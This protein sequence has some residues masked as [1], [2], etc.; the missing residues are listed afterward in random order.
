M[1]VGCLEA[2]SLEASGTGESRASAR[3]RQYSK[4]TRSLPVHCQPAKFKI[5]LEAGNC[6]FDKATGL[7]R[8]KSL[9]AIVGRRVHSTEETEAFRTSPIANPE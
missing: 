3:S 9:K 4:H 7:P 6:A 1:H 2:R 5:T 8:L